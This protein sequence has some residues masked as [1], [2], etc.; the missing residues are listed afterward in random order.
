VVASARWVVRAMSQV[1]DVAVVVAA[2][3]A[4]QANAWSP[5]LKWLSILSTSLW[6]RSHA[7]HLLP[8]LRRVVA[9]QTVDTINGCPVAQ[10]VQTTYRCRYLLRLFTHTCTSSFQR[11][12]RKREGTRQESPEERTHRLQVV[13]VQ[14]QMWAAQDAILLRTV[15]VSQT[16]HPVAVLM[17]MWKT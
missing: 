2:V 1:P 3:A 14:L 16:S 17:Q 5:A 11:I 6:A 4:V 7:T 13:M 15:M 10:H 8:A 9:L 12:S